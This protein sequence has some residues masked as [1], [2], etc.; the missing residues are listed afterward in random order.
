M[1]IF[2]ASL[3]S[4]S[5]DRGINEQLDSIEESLS[6]DPAAAYEKL[7]SISSKQRGSKSTQARYALLMSLAM[8]KN[9]IDTDNDSLIRVAVHY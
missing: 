1:P 9:Y 7:T 8:D 3:F 4:L 5:C 2:L 6:T